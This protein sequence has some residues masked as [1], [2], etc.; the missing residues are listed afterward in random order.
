MS[1]RPIVFQHVCDC[2][3]CA[4]STGDANVKYT[5]HS[6]CTL[7]KV[8]R[9][10]SNTSASSAIDHYTIS[11]FSFFLGGGWIDF[12]LSQQGLNWHQ[13]FGLCTGGA[14]AMS[15]ARSGFCASVEELFHCFLHKTASRAGG[16]RGSQL[17]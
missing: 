17:R 11:F 10:G 12:V 6:T 8:N 5:A 15:G 7:T 13:R 16:C 9:H 4:D 14:P 2:S 1:S 3:N